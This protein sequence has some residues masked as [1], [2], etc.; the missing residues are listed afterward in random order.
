MYVC[1]NRQDILVV[2][3]KVGGIRGR[4]GTFCIIQARYVKINPNLH[5]GRTTFLSR[6]ET[7]FQISF[8]Q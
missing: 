4:I 5:F 6:I 8:P 3:Y 7:I 2:N 1:Q